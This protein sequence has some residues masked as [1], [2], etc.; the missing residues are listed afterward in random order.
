[1]NIEGRQIP[2]DRKCC[3]NCEHAALSYKWNCYNDIESICLYGHFITIEWYKDI[4][5]GKWILPGGGEPG[6]CQF[7]KRTGMLDIIGKRYEK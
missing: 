2:D 3:A 7:K 4:T 1:M 5:K 6:K